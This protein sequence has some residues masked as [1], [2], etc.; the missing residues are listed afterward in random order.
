MPCWLVWGVKMFI[1]Q[2][3]PAPASDSACIS[4]PK[5]PERAIIGRIGQSMHAHASHCISLLKAGLEIKT[6]SDVTV[7][8]T[9]HLDGSSDGADTLCTEFL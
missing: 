4:E 8:C 6:G 1:D 9:K 3:M 2:V 7:K 5:L